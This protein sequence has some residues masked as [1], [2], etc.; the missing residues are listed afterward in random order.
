MIATPD[1][2][3]PLGG[4]TVTLTGETFGAT[5][6]LPVLVAG[7]VATVVSWSNSAVVITT[8]RVP[9]STGLTSITWNGNSAPYTANRPLADRAEEELAQMLAAALVDDGFYFN[10]DG[11]KQVKVLRRDPW[12]DDSSDKY[13]RS[14]VCHL[15]AD[16]ENDEPY[17]Y[18]KDNITIMVIGIV[19]S[20]LD[21][22][23]DLN[24]L[25][26]FYAADVAKALCT[27]RGIGGIVNDVR[28]TQVEFM[29]ADVTNAMEVNI[30]LAVQVQH[31]FQNHNKNE[32]SVP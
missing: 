10:H 19:K 29:G 15:L 13:P 26:H 9:F 5:Q 28:I 31:Y 25:C 24:S 23:S 32:G 20:D 16:V 11:D 22:A 7:V 14:F 1:N 6:S 12:T 18:D 21:D 4:Q 17:G 2:G 30:M 27:D 3:T 8:P